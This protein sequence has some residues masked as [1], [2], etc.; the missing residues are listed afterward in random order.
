MS[1]VV[2]SV[3]VGRVV[4]TP[5]S[6]LGRTGID[7]HPVE[8]RVRATVTGLEGDEV[9]D[10]I[11]HGGI[12]QA[13]YAYDRAAMDR[14]AAELG[15]ALGAGAFGE[16]L[17]IAGIDMNASVI[18][19]RWRIGEAEFEISSPRTPCGTFQNHMQEKRWVRRFG[20]K[21]DVGLYLRVLTEGTVGAGDA[22]DLLHRPAHGLTVGETFRAITTERELMPRLIDVPELPQKYRDRAAEYL[23]MQTR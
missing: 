18:G 19:E 13:V 17:A 9:A 22:V 8:G 20:V 4:D 11:H 3:S 1:A 23:A 7:K 10:D 16:N 15:R 14:W 6:L 21:G 5:G 2:V 12:D